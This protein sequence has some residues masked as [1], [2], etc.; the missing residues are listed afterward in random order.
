MAFAMVIPALLFPAP[1]L[2]AVQVSAVPAGPSCGACSVE[3]VSVV[4]FGA[5]EDPAGVGRTGSGGPEPRGSLRRD[6]VHV[7]R[8]SHHLR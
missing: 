5:V 6:V 7:S 8:R 4:T 1:I 2:G 3:L